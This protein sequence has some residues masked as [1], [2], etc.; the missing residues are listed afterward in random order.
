MGV[1]RN[2]GNFFYNLDRSIASL[3]GASPQD[4]ISSQ[5]GRA[6]KKDDEVAELLCSA[7]NKIDPGH[8]DHAV[9]HANKLDQADDKVEK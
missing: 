4:T 9:A 8:C 1:F 7:L 3:L 2:L 6:A 5:A